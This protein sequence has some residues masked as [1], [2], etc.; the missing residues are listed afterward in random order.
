MK[1]CILFY[2]IHCRHILRLNIFLSIYMIL[3][4]MLNAFPLAYYR[5]DKGGFN[6]NFYIFSFWLG[7]SFLIVECNVLLGLSTSLV[8]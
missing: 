1:A 5:K 3:S 4:S 6:F 8:H 2:K 7:L